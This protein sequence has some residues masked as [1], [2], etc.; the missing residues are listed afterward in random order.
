MEIGVVGA[1]LAIAAA[2]GVAIARPARVQ[3]LAA[4]EWGVLAIGIALAVRALLG[5]A[6]I[7]SADASPQPVALRSAGAFLVVSALAV[8]ALGPRRLQ[9]I[10]AWLLRQPC[11]LVR[12]AGI[13]ACTAGGVLVAL[14]F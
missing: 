12:L 6:L 10:A 2:G 1:G 5:V 11:D 14:A 8:P 7:A 9:R 13:A 3:A 4:A